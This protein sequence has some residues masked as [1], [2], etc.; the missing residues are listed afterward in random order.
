MFRIFWST[1]INQRFL[2]WS[3]FFCLFFRPAV[4]IYFLLVKIVENYEILMIMSKCNAWLQSSH[5]CRTLKILSLQY[6][7]FQL[8]TY[9][10]F[11]ILDSILFCIIFQVALESEMQLGPNL[12][13]LENRIYDSKSIMSVLYPRLIL[14]SLLQHLWLL[15]DV[16][17]DN[18]LT[19][20]CLCRWTRNAFSNFMVSI[21][22]IS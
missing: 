6:F 8:S 18:E 10:H 16:K 5:I 12:L 2:I 19:V 15:L 9:T 7:L 22:L 20:S 1:L 4:G 13:L 17:R 11:S 14:S 21:N 3:I